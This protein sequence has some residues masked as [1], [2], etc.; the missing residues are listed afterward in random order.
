M[1]LAGAPFGINSFSGDSGSATGSILS[2]V[3]AGCGASSEQTIVSTA[4]GATSNK[5][6]P[7]DSVL[8]GLSLWFSGFTLESSGATRR[9]S[10]RFMV[11]VYLAVY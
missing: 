11:S 10:S 9:V 6:L 7:M 5:V 1:F 8:C 4:F 3:L 2:L